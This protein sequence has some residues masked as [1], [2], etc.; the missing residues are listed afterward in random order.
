M[1]LLKLHAVI[2]DIEK[3]FHAHRDVSY[4]I[5]NYVKRLIYYSDD[6]T[7]KKTTA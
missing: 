3:A 2:K 7:L 4:N 6:V 1:K 5:F